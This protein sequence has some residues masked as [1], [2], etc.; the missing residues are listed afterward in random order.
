M[1]DRKARNAASA[2]ALEVYKAAELLAS[3][4]YQ[5]V[6]KPAEAIYQAVSRAA[7]RAYQETHYSIGNSES[8]AAQEAAF[9][10]LLCDAAKSRDTIVAPAK[11]RYHAVVAAAFAVYIETTAKIA[12]GDLS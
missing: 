5:A 12:S 9:N 4:E 2:S 7:H 1:S 6:L 10:T 8:R 11:A 3:V